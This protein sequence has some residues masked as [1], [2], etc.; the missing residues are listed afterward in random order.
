[1]IEV[2]RRGRPY[3]RLVPA[4]PSQPELEEAA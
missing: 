3:A 1:V 4:R 2:S